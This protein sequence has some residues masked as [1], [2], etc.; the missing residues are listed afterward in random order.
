M[1]RWRTAA[2][3]CIVM[4]LVPVSAL[5]QY[6]DLDSAMAGLG[7]G[8]ERGEAQPIVEGVAAGDKVMLDF[9]GLIRESGFFGKDQASY[10]LDELFNKTRPSGFRQV[11][12]RKQS[13]EGQYHITATWTVEQGGEA[14]ERDLYITLQNKNDRWTV[15]VIRSPN[16]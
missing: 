4:L 15:A 13:A 5:A 3:A 8:F 1:K 7:R 11:S 16:R 2:I 12:A 9:P 14:Q 6:R 10:L